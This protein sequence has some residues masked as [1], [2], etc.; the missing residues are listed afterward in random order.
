M[1]IL[2]SITPSY[3]DAMSDFM[4]VCK[5]LNTGICIYLYV[6]QRSHRREPFMLKEI[7]LM[8]DDGR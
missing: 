3:S 8:N 7:V 5:E 1:T 2:D 6:W 4:E